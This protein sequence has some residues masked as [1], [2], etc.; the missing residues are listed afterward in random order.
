MSRAPAPK[1]ANN[2]TTA[3][4]PYGSM[5]AYPM[6]APMN[7]GMHPMQSVYSNMQLQQPLQSQPVALT[8]QQMPFDP[9]AGHGGYYPNAHAAH[10]PGSTM[11]NVSVVDFKPDVMAQHQ[12]NQLHQNYNAMGSP[13]VPTMGLIGSDGRYQPVTAAASSYGRQEDF[14]NRSFEDNPYAHHPSRNTGS[15]YNREDTYPDIESIVNRRVD[16]RMKAAGMQQTGS[17][18]LHSIRETDSRKPLHTTSANFGNKSTS[19]QRD[20]VGAAVRDVLKKYEVKRETPSSDKRTA[21]ASRYADPHYG[22]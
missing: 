10:P 18:A 12:M 11:H 5:A 17:N 7:Q 14:N 4:N 16:K 15:A 3:P 22:Y 9:Y 13:S 6:T 2:V 8:Q 1:I 21:S 20:I 19:E